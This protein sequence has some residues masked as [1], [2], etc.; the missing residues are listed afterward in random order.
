M[1]YAQQRGFSLIEILTVISIIAV[2]A[3]VGFYGLR[4]PSQSQQISGA[5]DIAAGLMNQARLI[6]MTQGLGARLVIDDGTDINFKHRRIAIFEATPNPAGSGLLWL[7]NSKPVIIDTGIYFLPDQSIG[8]MSGDSYD[9][10]SAAQQDGTSGSPSLVYEYDGRGQLING[11]ASMVFTGGV[12]PTAGQ[13][14]PD[15]P[16]T[17]LALRR[18]FLLRKNGRPTYFKDT[19]QI[20]AFFTQH[21]P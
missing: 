6:A 18:G 1:K 16:P 2:L 8:Y 5:T 3:G 17:M 15:F 12:P 10:R 14:I 4:G 19:N 11:T 20:E 9:F 13:L 7:L 21:T